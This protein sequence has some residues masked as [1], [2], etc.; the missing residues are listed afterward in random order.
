[1]C[2]CYE[3]EKKTNEV[4][5][6]VLIFGPCFESVIECLKQSEDAFQLA[7]NPVVN[8]VDDLVETERKMGA[9]FDDFCDEI[10]LMG[11]N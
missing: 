1:M 7:K 3:I 10:R 6:K 5:H 8:F 9:N 11:D 4:F 2:A